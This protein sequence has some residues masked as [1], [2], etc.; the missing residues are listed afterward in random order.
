MEKLDYIKSLYSKYLNDTIDNQEKEF[1]Y[2]FFDQASDEDLNKIITTSFESD[3]QIPSNLEYLEKDVQRIF[4][5]IK[6]RTENVQP[7]LALKNN[8]WVRYGLIAVAALLLLGLS[9]GLYLYISKS[10][11]HTPALLSDKQIKVNPGTDKATL[12]LD[13]GRTILLDTVSSGY[14]PTQAGVDVAK[15]G[16][17]QLAYNATSNPSSQLVYNTIKIPRGGQFQVI[18]PDNTHVWLNAASSIKFPIAFLGNSREVTITGE[19]YFEVSKNKN[20]PFRVKTADQTVEVLGTHFN[21]NSYSDEP[22]TVTT[23]AEGSVRVNLGSSSNDYSHAMTI[24]PGQQTSTTKDNITVGTADLDAALAW[25]NNQIY[26][27]QASIQTIMRQVSRWYNIEVE[28]K[29]KIP[30]RKFTGGIYRTDNLNDLLK[31]LMLNDLHFELINNT[32]IVK[33]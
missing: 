16:K 24:V 5:K 13:D 1:L 4:Q 23:L 21:V 27:K 8:L 10:E 3:Y 32:L 12:T 15:V 18:L 29:G 33:P 19:A 17:G 6:M 11:N 22:A 7:I 30:N 26:F 14:L 28:Y 31:I 20:K 2:N 9:F 25:K